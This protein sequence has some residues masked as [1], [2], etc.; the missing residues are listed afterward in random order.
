MSSVYGE[1]NPGSEKL[2]DLQKASVG[3]KAETR[4]LPVLLIGHAVP[5]PLGLCC[6]FC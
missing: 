3:G 2:A 1:G 6:L 4:F 5:S